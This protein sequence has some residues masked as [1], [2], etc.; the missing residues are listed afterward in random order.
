MM[1]VL[2]GVRATHIS[3]AITL[4]K[5][6]GYV[7]HSSG[8]ENMGTVDFKRN[9]N[10]SAID[11]VGT[12]D[13]F[14]NQCAKPFDVFEQIG[15]EMGICGGMAG[16][17]DII[18]GVSAWNAITAHEERDAI[19]YS[20]RPGSSFDRSLGGNNTPFFAYNDVQ[21][22]GETN[23]GSLRHWVSHA[24][25]LD[26]T[27]LA[28]PVLAPGE[29]LIVSKDAFDGQRVYRTVSSDNREFIPD[30][31]LPFFLYDDLEK[32]YNRKCRSFEPWMEEHHLMVPGNVNGAVLARVTADN[33]DPCVACEDC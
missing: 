14:C 6:G 23:G 30:A 27:G 26:H 29:V 13:D 9:A 17:V 15:R 24:M 21:F 31:G 8:T 19:K 1:A 20:Q 28:V 5:T 22:K 32:E 33:C 3:E 4:L 25:Y 11:L 16:T 2:D 10:L 12:N 7:L 18:Y